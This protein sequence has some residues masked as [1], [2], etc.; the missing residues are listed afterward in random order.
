MRGYIFLIIF[1]AC[2]VPLFSKADGCRI[3]T[4]FYNIPASVLLGINLGS[5]LVA[6]TTPGTNS[7]GC[8]KGTVSS[9]KSCYVCTG[10]GGVI[11]AVGLGSALEVITCSSGVAT[12]GTYYSNYVLECNL[13]DYSLP[14]ATAA[15]L[16]GIFVIRRR[17]KQ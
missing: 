8:Y 1:L 2:S 15:G 4:T 13:D 17:N 9:A 5:T 14:L 3:N 12:K 6:Y 11:L 16:F 7:N 10:G